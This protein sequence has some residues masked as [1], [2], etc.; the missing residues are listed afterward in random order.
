M[1]GDID[2]SNNTHMIRYGHV[3]G[4][5]RQHKHSMATHAFIA[6]P[7]E[8]PSLQRSENSCCFLCPFFYMKCI[9][10]I[11][12]LSSPQN[13]ALL[14]RSLSLSLPHS[15]SQ[16]HTHIAASSRVY[17][18]R[19]C[20]DPWSAATH[21]LFVSLSDWRGSTWV[22]DGKQ[23]DGRAELSVR[24][25][26]QSGPMAELRADRVGRAWI[27]D[28]FWTLQ[29]NRQH[30]AQ[31]GW[32]PVYKKENGKRSVSQNPEVLQF[33][34]EVDPISREGYRAEPMQW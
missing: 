26:G 5:C 8:W 28:Y 18:E 17:L 32:G 12:L 33:L 22:L 27:F 16:T 3:L 24:S 13:L 10:P 19:A 7:T 34:A 23:C 1:F 21:R 4:S 15:L 25:Q 11:I 20:G 31:K 14:S 29:M 30:T 9:K 6:D 2:T